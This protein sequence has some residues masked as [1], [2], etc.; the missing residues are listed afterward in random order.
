MSKFTQVIQVETN[1]DL[2]GRNDSFEIYTIDSDFMI[3]IWDLNFRYP[4]DIEDDKFSRRGGRC[5]ES[6][7]M[8]PDPRYDRLI[9]VADGFKNDLSRGAENLGAIK[10]RVICSDLIKRLR[11]NQLPKDQLDAE[12]EQDRMIALCDNAGILQ[13]NNLNSGNL[14]FSLTNKRNKV[15]INCLHF[16]NQGKL[17]IAG[18]GNDGS[19]VFFYRPPVDASK[20]TQLEPGNDSY[21]VKRD[22]HRGEINH[23]DHSIEFIVFGGADN[24]LSIWKIMGQQLV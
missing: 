24:K 21:V 14:L 13:V 5:K 6:I 8:E 22:I 15:M 10:R 19:I 3:K 4:K 7:I 2:K 23:I 18:G 9:S 1:F 16:I 17:L 12:K 20:E 11:K